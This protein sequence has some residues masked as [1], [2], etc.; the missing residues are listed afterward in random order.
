MTRGTS[1]LG[2]RLVRGAWHWLGLVGWAACIGLVALMPQ[3]ATAQA[4]EAVAL[5]G[6]LGALRELSGADPNKVQALLPALRDDVVRAGLLGLRLEVDELECRVFA[7]LDLSQAIRVAAAGVAVGRG[8]TDAPSSLAW[9]RLRAC[10][11][12]VLMDGGDVA[13]GERELDEVLA[14]S[15]ADEFVSARALAL[16]ERGTH[17]SRMGEMIEGQKDLLRAC[18]LLKA[19]AGSDRD[20]VLCL[21]SLANHHKRIGDLDEAMAMLG[22]LR[23]RA[24]ARAARFDES[25]YAY[26]MAE[27]H[28][29]RDDWVQALASFNEAAALARAVR[30]NAGLAYAEMGIAGSLR[31]M[32]DPVQ[33]LSHVDKALQLLDETADPGHALRGKVLRARVLMALGRAQEADAELRPLEPR[34]RAMKHDWLLAQWMAARAETAAALGRWSEAYQSMMEGR[35]LND[36]LRNQ[37]LSEMATRLRLQFN[38]ER[39]LAELRSLRSL[40]EQG[41][42]LRRTQWVAIGLF[43]LLLLASVGFAAAKFLQAKAL[44]VLAATDE[45]TGLPNRRAILAYAEQQMRLAGD[46]GK[47]L[48]VLMIDIDHFKRINDAHGHAVG[49]E[50]LHHV[51]Q[52]LPSA[53]RTRDRLG[54]IGGEEFLVVLP[55]ANAAR[56]IAVAHR[57]REAIAARPLA[58]P[59]GKL[60]VTV[61]IG[62]AQWL[63][64]SERI[65][66]LLARVDTALYRAKADGRDTV[67]LAA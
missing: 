13:A 37:G 39:D 32:G 66:D 55:E 29:L 60:R 18:D 54:R 5:E 48:S 25:I 17:R 46:T 50:V 67:S 1:F 19:P 58:R 4:D 11:A 41:D 22:Q 65:D 49:D 63:A 31:R 42:A 33:A 24:R 64:R 15:T 30:N 40:N 8:V 45:L 9:L 12:A 28:F 7:D 16:M 43:V 57:I 38:R 52:V 27:V 62:A 14:S 26:G 56:A 61:S 47:S 51:G 10:H 21:G 2:T 23:A 59:A 35:G 44:K 20:L 3:P 53:L 34:V 6:R 36:R